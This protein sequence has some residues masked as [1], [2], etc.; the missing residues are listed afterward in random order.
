M[1]VTIFNILVVIYMVQ[2]HFFENFNPTGREFATL[3]VLGLFA[4]LNEK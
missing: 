1:I 4:A 3:M 2:L